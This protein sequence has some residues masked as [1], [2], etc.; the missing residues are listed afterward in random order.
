MAAGPQAMDEEEVR[1][2]LPVRTERLYGEEPAYRPHGRRHAANPGPHNVVDA[3]RDF[4]WV[5]DLMG[6]GGWSDGCCWVFVGAGQSPH[7]DFEGKKATVCFSIVGAGGG[8]LVGA[9]WV[10]L[11]QATYTQPNHQLACLPACRRAEAG[12]GPDSSAGLAAMF[13][14]PREMLFHGSFEE[15]KQQAQEQ[16]RWLVSTCPALCGTASCSWGAAE[17]CDEPRCPWRHIAAPAARL[18]LLPLPHYCGCRSSTC[19]APAS[20]APQ[21]CLTTPLCPLLPCPCSAT[22]HYRCRL[23]TCRAPASLRRTA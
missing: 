4:R 22:P 16:G 12:A 17:G 2:P 5:L 3:V 8:V 7:P 14:P 19:R 6:G 9:C 18:P 15:A 21:H 23:S 10:L 11:T 1:A 13:E 20:V